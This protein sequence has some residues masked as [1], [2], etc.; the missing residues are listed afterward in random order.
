MM[1][2]EHEVWRQGLLLSRGASWIQANVYLMH[3]GDQ[4]II[5]KDFSRSP[6]VI[7]DTFC[8]LILAREAR[9]L[10]LLNDS[11]ITPRYLGRLN[12]YAYAMEYIEGENFRLKKHISSITHLAAMEKAVCRMHELGVAHNDLHGKNIIITNSGDFYF[13]DFASA[14]FKNKKHNPF[15]WVSNKLFRFFALVDRSKITLFKEKYDPSSLTSDDKQF[16][17][18][19]KTTSFFTT[20]WKK[21]VNGPLLRKRTWKKRKERIQQWLHL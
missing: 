17:I 8:R 9:A 6:R 12:D 4:K 18:V 2:I 14:F 16:L 13:I 20:V 11:G 21:L 10:Q 15:S 1:I 7:R 3:H 5:V 19:K